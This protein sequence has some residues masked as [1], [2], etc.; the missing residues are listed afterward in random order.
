MFHEEIKIHIVSLFKIYVDNTI[1]NSSCPEM[2]NDW[3]KIMRDKIE[4]NMRSELKLFFE[5]SYN[6]NCLLLM[7]G[8]ATLQKV[9]PLEGSQ[10]ACNPYQAVYLTNVV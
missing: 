3:L 7:R 9:L 4:E 6:S 8:F 10:E 1:L 5:S 2:Y